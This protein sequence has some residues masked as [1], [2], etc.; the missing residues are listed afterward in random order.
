MRCLRN[1]KPLLQTQYLA[2]GGR[3]AFIVTCSQYIHAGRCKEEII[4]WEEEEEEEELELLVG[5]MRP[6]HT[7]GWLR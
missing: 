6:P 3:A 5:S 1:L 2:A 4:A 7:R